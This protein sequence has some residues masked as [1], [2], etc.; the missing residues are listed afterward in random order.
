MPSARAARPRLTIVTPV[1]NEETN[2][3]AFKAALSETVL[4]APDLDA[5]VIFVDD[6]S[7]DGSWPKLQLF[8][9]SSPRFTAIRLSRNFGYHLALAAG[10]DHVDSG[11]DI[12]ATLACDLQDPP[13]TLLAFVHEWRRGA[14]IVWGA[15]RERAERR[16]R[17]AV[18]ALLESAVRRFA[19]PR[20]SLVRTGSF[21]L[22]DRAVLECFRQFREQSRVTFALVAWTGFNQAVVHYDRR[23]RRSGRSGWSTGSLFSTA[24]D[25]LMGF[26][27]LPARFLTILGFFLS[28]VSALVLVY[29]IAVWVVRDVQPGWTGIMGTMTVFF[30]LVFMMLGLIGE[31]LYR[32]FVETKH[33]PLY[34]VAD[35]AGS[36]FES[37]TYH[38]PVRPA[39]GES[40][41]DNTSGSS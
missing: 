4:A 34:F 26:S 19:M 10:F 24:Y 17:K 8:A 16:W 11:A 6:G 22:M 35:R 38:G 5:H 27:P 32:I 36:S 39:R 1:Y 7:N 3:E 37:E 28:G 21:L 12:V 23:P 14:D 30:G 13:E 18:S 41:G 20:S 25:V 33:R 40:Q 29:L 31:Y 2:L 15:R 9:E